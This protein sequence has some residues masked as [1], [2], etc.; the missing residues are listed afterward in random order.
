MS[1]PDALQA[2][3]L[4]P[5]LPSLGPNKRPDILPLD[6]CQQSIEKALVSSTIPEYS[7]PL[8]HST[9]LL[10]HDHLDASHSISQDIQSSDGSFLHGIMH[11]RE[12]DYPNAKYW[13]TRTGSNEAF[14]AIQARAEEVLKESSLA[15]LCSGDW[16]PF[17]MV[18]AVSQASPGTPEYRTLQEIQRIEFEVLL[19]RFCA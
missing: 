7:H 13:F 14:P 12:P 2:L 18:D 1:V 11:R 15:H 10:W 19:E 5:S 16:D 8:I 17:S 9:A 4:T 3:F 6:Q